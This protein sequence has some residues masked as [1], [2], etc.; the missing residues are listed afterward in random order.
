[1]KI[2][3]CDDQKIHLEHILTRV[4]Q[5]CPQSEIKTFQEILEFFE[6]INAGIIFDIVFMDIEWVGEVQGG[7]DFAAQLYKRSPDTKIVFVTGH[8]QRYFQEI[9]LKHINLKGYVAKPID[10]D[11]LRKI[12]EKI[13]AETLLEKKQKLLISF[14]N[15]VTSLNP[16]DILYIESRARIASIY[17]RDGEV[18]L[19]YEKLGVL[20]SRLPEKFCFAHKSFLVNMDYIRRIG[21]EVLIL[22]ENLEIPVSKMRRAEIRERYFRHVS[23]RI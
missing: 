9:F 4:S 2:A 13:Q 17:A 16:N 20:R 8:Q 11:I 23:L 14:N 7:I 1:M 18:Y 10:I 21:R 22:E 3:I 15:M 12:V 5:V 19:C 6:N